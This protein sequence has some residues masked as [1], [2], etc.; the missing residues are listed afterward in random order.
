MEREID[1]LLDEKRRL[2]HYILEQGRVRFEQG[3]RALQRH[4][5]VGIWTY[6]RTARLGHLLTAPVIY[7][8]YQD[9]NITGHHNYAVPAYLFPQ[10]T[11][12]R[13]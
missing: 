8:V 10:C 9:N 7:G 1:Q 6:L 4:Q 12:F 5:K 2:F 11:A 13:A 3:M